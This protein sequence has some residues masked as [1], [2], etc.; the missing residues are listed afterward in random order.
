M[1][2]Y[3]SVDGSGELG[4]TDPIVRASFAC[5]VGG[6]N[7]DIERFEHSSGLP[8]NVSVALYRISALWPLCLEEEALT[9][10]PAVLP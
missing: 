6:Y 1:I 4:T 9:S 5:R 7:L 3:A 8:S 10:R 2:Y